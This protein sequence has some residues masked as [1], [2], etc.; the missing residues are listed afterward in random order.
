MK[1]W[2]YGEGLIY[3]RWFIYQFTY[4]PEEGQANPC[5][6]TYWSLRIQPFAVLSAFPAV[7]VQAFISAPC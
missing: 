6:P 5:Q 2:Q 3:F 4:G 7:L 1:G